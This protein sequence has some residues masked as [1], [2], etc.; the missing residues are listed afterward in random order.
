[1]ATL[2][3]TV[4]IG[5][6]GCIDDPGVGLPST[7]RTGRRSTTP[8]SSEPRQRELDDEALLAKVRSSIVRIEI[9]TC[10]GVG[11]GTGWMLEAGKVVTNRH[12]IGDSRSAEL[13]TWDGH[14]VSVTAMSVS[15]SSDLGFVDVTGASRLRPLE[16]RTEPVRA[17][18]RIGIVGYPGGGR[19]TVKT[20]VA[21]DVVPGVEGT[22]RN[23]LRLTTVVQPGNSGGPAVDMQGRAVGVVFAELVRE[24]HA[25][26]IPMDEVR[27]ASSSSLTT[28]TALC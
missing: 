3:L 7:T 9:E 10:E 24:D 4:A 20:G 19:L 11:V 13:L 16:V 2:V 6:S 18:E 27:A 14:G 8:T 21:V 23:W 15:E 1:M 26:I 25:L 22:A 5:V 28:P 12:V 17:G